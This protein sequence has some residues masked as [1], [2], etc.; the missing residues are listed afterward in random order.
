MDDTTLSCVAD[1]L[2]GDAMDII[3]LGASDGLP[4]VNWAN[5]VEKLDAGSPPEFIF[6]IPFQISLSKEAGKPAQKH[7]ET[8]HDDTSVGLRNRAM[9][10]EVR[11]QF[12]ASVASCFLPARVIA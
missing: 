10:P 9:M 8:C 7:T 5:V 12:S 6:Q 1:Y 11:S 2:K 4:P 3:N